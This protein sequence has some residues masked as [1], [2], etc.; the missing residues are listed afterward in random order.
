MKITASAERRIEAPADRIYGYIRD[1]RNHHPNFLPSQFSDF[2]VE[3]GGVGAGTVHRFTM[4]LAGRATTFR[5]RVGEP[6]PGRILI[7]SDPSR[8]V[9][10]TFTVEPD[11]GGSR[12][13]IETRWFTDGVQGLVERLV[14]SRLLRRVYV[15]ELALLDAY[16]TDA[17]TTSRTRLIPAVGR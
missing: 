9:L 11:Q 12:V 4:T 1:F 13:R 5:S 10:T 6:D 14:A 2:E 15:A 8:R 3:V 16:A 17:A 7:E